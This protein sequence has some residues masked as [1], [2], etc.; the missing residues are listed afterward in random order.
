VVGVQIVTINSWLDKQNTTT[1]RELRLVPDT[2]REKSGSAEA[3][4]VLDD[5]PVEMPTTQADYFSQPAS[6][7]S[8]TVQLRNGSRVEL[9]GQNAVHLFDELL[10]GLFSHD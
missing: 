2:Q 6:V 5:V 10:K 9:S 4:L 7:N 8:I 3:S 1:I